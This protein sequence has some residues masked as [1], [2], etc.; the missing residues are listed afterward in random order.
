MEP[1]SDSTRPT[2][3]RL[4][5]T[6]PAGGGTRVA[7]HGDIDMATSDDFRETVMRLAG[8]PEVTGL[9]LDAAGLGFIDSNGITV[10]VKAHR[11]AADRGIGF[12]VV[13]AREPIRGL[14]ELLG[15][16]AMLTGTPAG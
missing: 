1:T 2:E 16:H 4:D 5:I 3:L 13:N 9:V 10:L 7:M 15:V 6:H 14:F 12:G 8:D 11:V